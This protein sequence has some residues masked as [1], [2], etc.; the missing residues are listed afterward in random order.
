MTNQ[1]RAQKS[2]NIPATPM[3]Q[4]A[5]VLSMKYGYAIIAIPINIGFHRLKRL[6]KM[7]PTKPILLKNS[8]ARRFAA[9]MFGMTRSTAKITPGLA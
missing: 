3:A 5:S 8:P 1:L 4:S 6:P 9:E 2:A 7:N